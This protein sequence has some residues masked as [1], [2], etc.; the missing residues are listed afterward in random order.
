MRS[1]KSWEDQV[2]HGFIGFI[3]FGFHSEK[4]EKSLE[5]L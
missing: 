5:R 4:D 1:E 3:D 2:I